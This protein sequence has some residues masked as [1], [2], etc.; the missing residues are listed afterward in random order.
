MVCLV[1]AWNRAAQPLRQYPFLTVFLMNLNNNIELLGNN[2]TLPTPSTIGTGVN[3]DISGDNF[4]LISNSTSK[5]LVILFSGTYKNGGRF[6]FWNV[7]QALKPYANVLLLNNGKNQWYQQGIPDFGKSLADSIAYIESLAKKLNASEIYTIGVSMGG[8]GAILL[9]RSLNAKVLAFGID[10]LVCIPGS[11]SLKSMHTSTKI[12]HPDLK[13]LL[14]QRKLDLT[15]IVGEMDI[16]DL[17]GAAR[18]SHIP[19]VKTISVRGMDHGGGRYIDK[20]QGLANFIKCFIENKNLPTLNEE[21]SALSSPGLIEKLYQAHC[22]GLEEEWEESFEILSPLVLENP[23]SE[24]AHYS[25]GLTLIKLKKFDEA[26]KHLCFVAAMI[27]YFISGRFYLAYCLRMDK[28]Y[29]TALHMF[30]EQLKEK[31]ESAP[32]LFNIGLIHLSL[33]SKPAAI[34]FIKKAVEIQ[35]NKNIYTKKLESLTKQ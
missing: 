10:S 14:T 35:P 13:P 16:L 30:L 31:P 32:T 24:I 5:K 7:A 22:L 1:G 11:R 23:M 8:F 6:D 3:S 21:G 17:F 19:G 20:T 26:R 2:Q 25:L 29:K 34:S 9:G 18:I 27:P 33:G 28:Q 12:A 15:L 4:L